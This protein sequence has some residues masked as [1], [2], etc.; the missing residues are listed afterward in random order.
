VDP[1]FTW[2]PPMNEGG[3]EAP[4]ARGKPKSVALSTLALGV[5][6]PLG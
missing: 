6:Q 2:K 5:F 1:T 3:K 4:C